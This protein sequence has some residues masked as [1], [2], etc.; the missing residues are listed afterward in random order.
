MINVYVYVGIYVR[1]ALL[2][3][4]VFQIVTHYKFRFYPKKGN[5]HVHLHFP[6]Y[7]PFKQSG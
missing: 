5:F 1:L 4:V 3:T 7:I 2:L 6:D